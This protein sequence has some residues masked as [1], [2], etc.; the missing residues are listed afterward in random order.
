MAFRREALPFA[1]LSTEERAAVAGSIAAN[2]S[3]RFE[4][5]IDQIGAILSSADSVR[6]LA[7]L[8]A[9]HLRSLLPEPG[10]PIREGPILQHH[11]ELLQAFALRQSRQ[12]A[13]DASPLEG[14]TERYAH[15][16]ETGR[17]LET[18][19]RDA[20][21]AFHLKRLNAASEAASDL[22][23]S[24]L[25]VAEA[26]RGQTEAIRNWGFPHQIVRT[27]QRI[28]ERLDQRAAAAVGF[29][30][31]PLPLGFD[32]LVR[33][34][35]QRLHEYTLRLRKLFHAKS[36]ADLATRCPQQFPNIFWGPDDTQAFL[37]ANTTS[38]EQAKW[39]TIWIADHE[40][41]PSIF[42][43]DVEDFNG[44]FG[45]AYDHA[46][47]VTLIDRMSLG[48][49]S[50]QN[51]SVEYLFLDNPIWTR[52]FIRM[53]ET[54]IFIPIPNLLYAFLL[55]I[56]FELV[57]ANEPLRGA[58]YQS[59]ASFL[60]EEVE[61]LFRSVLPSA[62]IWRGVQWKAPEDDRI[63]ENDLIVQMDTWLVILEAKSNIV[64]D[65]A[66]RG[67]LKRVER[68]IQETMVEPAVQSMRF[69]KLLKEHR[70]VHRFVDREDAA[71]EIDS[72]KI[73]RFVR[74]TIVLESVIPGCL[75]WNE[76]RRAGLARPD[77]PSTMAMGV[78]ELECL[79]QILLSP[80]EL[81]H[82]LQ[83]RTE[84]QANPVYSGDE[85][86]LLGFYLDNG[87][88]IGDKEFD[89]SYFN[90]I[91]VSFENVDPYFVARGRGESV[92]VPERKMTKFWRAM[93]D[94]LE[95]A[96][97]PNWIDSASVLLNVPYRMQREFERAIEKIKRIMRKGWR[98][99]EKDQICIV[100]IGPVQRA[101]AVAALAFRELPPHAVRTQLERAGGRA[102]AECRARRAVVLGFDVVGKRYPFSAVSYMQESDIERT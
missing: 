43:F 67:A 101:E 15:F 45:D 91:T 30:L 81:L 85:L 36:M 55:E 5:A 14:S 19:L 86:D 32:Q 66:R 28:L 84:L 102:L 79:V 75:T 94:N 88:I 98:R 90:L 71:V 47:T 51:H 95:R 76:L 89:S 92:P 35:E 42:T 58:Y 70:K 56:A 11:V 38:L 100:C 3:V 60:E 96:R 74:V 61:R 17:Q 12:P 40:H 34:V 25:S 2:A 52:P 1:H 13:S 73:T 93:I 7:W 26:L 4:T 18:I 20:A 39:L 69:E 54:T 83:R 78:Y 65:P 63:F 53:T 41:L 87:F 57:R 16:G 8:S 64:T 82:Y 29:A 31:S 99:S 62:K 6:L 48:F 33:T 46:T 21:M 68:E 44:A 59:R 23:K 9:Y 10:E 77:L 80:A 22:E 49:G 27:A 37:L 50:L 72:N 24:R 97:P